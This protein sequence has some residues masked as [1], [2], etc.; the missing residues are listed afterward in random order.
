[1]NN[2]DRARIRRLSASTLSPALSVIA[3][4]VRDQGQ[5]RET[6]AGIRGRSQREGRLE[7]LLRLGEPPIVEV[8]SPRKS[9]ASAS[10]EPA[11]A[12]LRAASNS[13]RARARSPCI[14][15]AR[16]Q[17]DQRL[18]RRLAVEGERRLRVRSGAPDV[19]DLD[20]EPRRECERERPQAG[21][22]RTFVRVF[23]NLRSR[24]P[25]QTTSGSAMK[26]PEQPSSSQCGWR[27]APPPPM[28]P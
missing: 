4:S 19:T 27:P 6:P 2:V 16:P 15:A 5:V 11:A 23:P 17:D 10:T 25:G 8:N 21:I 20:R 26:A 24:A 14:E 3:A 12:R 13:S 7:A 22:D 1:M 18:C 28:C 9:S